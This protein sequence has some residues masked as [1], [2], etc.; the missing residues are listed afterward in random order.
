MRNLAVEGQVL[1]LG[2]IDNGMV[3]ISMA[4]NPLTL[5][6]NPFCMNNINISL[7]SYNMYY[8]NGV[9]HTLLEYPRPLA[10]WVGKTMYDVLLESNN[11]RKGDLSDFIAIIDALPEIVVLMQDNS[12]TATTLFVPT[13]EAI[14]LSNLTW[15]KQGQDNNNST[16]IQ[17]LVLNHIVSGNFVRSCWWTIPLGTN[18]SDNQLRVESDAEQSLDLL[19]QNDSVVINGNV[20]IIQKDIFAENGVVQIIDKVLLLTQ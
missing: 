1:D 16:M 3:V 11:K 20:T 8:K 4:G 17:E 7:T 10:P 2:H 12:V 9:V 6:L 15:M 18:L 14:A 19:I 5:Q 13:N